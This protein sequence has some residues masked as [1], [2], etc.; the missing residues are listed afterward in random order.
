MAGSEPTIMCPSC[1][2]LVSSASGHCPECGHWLPTELPSRPPALDA[3]RALG[4]AGSGAPLRRAPSTAP[5]HGPFTTGR[6]PFAIL[7][8]ALPW[9]GVAAVIVLAG[10]WLTVPSSP[11]AT[12]ARP[13]LAAGAP[14]APRTSSPADS[15]SQSSPADVLDLDAALA[16]ATSKALRWHRDAQLL[17]ITVTEVVGGRIATASGGAIQI[18]FGTPPL[19]RRLG[20]GARVGPDQMLVRVDDRGEHTEQARGPAARSVA[21]PTCSF[22]RAWRAVVA[23]GVSPSEPLTMRFALDKRG[24]RA[25]WTARPD[26]SHEPTRML[27]GSS[28]AIILRR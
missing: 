22:D 26:G 1:S 24:Q 12:K 10:V 17:E 3:Q 11:D 5:P 8:A 18:R 14:V 25:V 21:P 23:S 9:V 20:P 16:R 4:A 28:C 6:T 27:D 7:R 2:V 13:R 19:G 15:G